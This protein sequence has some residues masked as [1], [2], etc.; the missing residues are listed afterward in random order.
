MEGDTVLLW[1]D[2]VQN[3]DRSELTLKK[4]GDRWLIRSFH[5]AYPR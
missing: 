1:S 4:S 5:T 3:G 2:P